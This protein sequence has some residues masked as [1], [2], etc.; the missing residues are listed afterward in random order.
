[1]QQGLQ[2]GTIDP[3]R[4]ESYLKLEKE[5]HYVALKQDARAR[6]EEQNK[7]KKIVKEQKRN[8]KRF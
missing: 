4:W 3:E 2:D 6:L 7:W 5:L 1:V 8:K